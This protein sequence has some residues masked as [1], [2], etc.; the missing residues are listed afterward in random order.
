MQQIS[1]FMTYSFWTLFIGLLM[2]QG[3]ILAQDNCVLKKDDDGIKIYLCE[4]E[5]SNFK[6]IIAE[7]EVPAT[8]S[9]Y[10][11]IVLDIASYKEWQYKAIDPHIVKKVSD[12][13]L[14]YYTEVQAPWPVNN[15]DLI[16]HLKMKQ[17]VINKTLT[18]ELTEIP[19]FLPEKKNVIRI[20]KAHSLLTVTP[21]SKGHVYVRYVLD[22]DPGGA[23]PA[24]IANMFAAQ[25]PWNT[26]NNFRNRVIAQGENRSS[27]PFIEDY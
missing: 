22:I 10:A 20:P 26:F 14:Y 23:I 27:A 2:L 16:F 11:A 18:V 8:L 9:Q 15:R 24:W 6:T 12:T 21:A 4:N 25:A 13:E 3:P 5:D 1:F 17:D 19:D 7:Y